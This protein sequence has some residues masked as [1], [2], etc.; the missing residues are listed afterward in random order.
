MPVQPGS[1]CCFPFFSK[2]AGKSSWFN[3]SLL[4]NILLPAVQVIGETLRLDHEVETVRRQCKGFEEELNLVYQIDE[5]IHST[6]RSHSGLAQLVG[7]SGRFLGIAYS[8]L[9]IPSKRIR[10]SATHSSWKSVNR[11]AVDKYLLE[12]LFPQLEGLRLPT[13]FEVPPVA[14]SDNPSEQGYQ[15][16]LSPLMDR[17]GNLEGVLAQLGRIRDVVFGESRHTIHVAYRSQGR[18]CHRAVIRSDDRPDESFRLRGP[19]ARVDEVAQDG[20]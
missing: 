5:K 9:L 2:N 6:S 3:P 4:K 12:S 13:V 8:V 10:V 17:S 14:G 19:V 20:R 1:A 11:K 15:A 16:L 18:I 7:K